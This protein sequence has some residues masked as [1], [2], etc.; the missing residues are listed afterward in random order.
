MVKIFSVCHGGI[1]SL[2]GH[3]DL[4]S[5]HDRHDDDDDL[6]VH[7]DPCA[8]GVLHHNGACRDV[9]LCRNDRHGGRSDDDRLSCGGRRGLRDVCG[10]VR[11]CGACLHR[12]GRHGSDD[13]CGNDPCGTSCGSRQCVH[14]CRGVRDGHAC[15][16]CGDVHARGVHHGRHVHP[17]VSCARLR[18]R[19]DVLHDDACHGVRDRPCGDGDVLCDLYRPYHH[20]RDGDAHGDHDHHHA[21]G[22]DHWPPRLDPWTRHRHIKQPNITL[23]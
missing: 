17:N 2:Y 20:G 21:H 11:A 14:L 10:D 6:H 4:P 16:L 1:P 22:G 5:C 9:R 12:G 19:G 8:H 15:R 7:G 13:P 3:H 18:V 23:L